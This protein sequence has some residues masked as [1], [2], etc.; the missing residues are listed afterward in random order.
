MHLVDLDLFTSG[1]AA[2]HAPAATSILFVW[3]ALGAS[4][5]IAG[6]LMVRT[7]NHGTVN[8]R[9]VLLSMAALMAGLV[10]AGTRPATT[11]L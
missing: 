10:V 7:Y 11:Q 9:F 1:V 5:L 8:K 4:I 3:G 6:L 2:N